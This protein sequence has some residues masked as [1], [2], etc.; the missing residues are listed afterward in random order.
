MAA[1]RALQ[2]GDVP[3]VW[4]R[5]LFDQGPLPKILDEPN[6]EHDVGAWLPLLS[7]GTDVSWAHVYALLD[8]ADG[9]FAKARSL[10]QAAI[11]YAW[12][13]HLLHGS[14]HFDELGVEPP[15]VR[16][17]QLQ[18]TP[19]V[20]AVHTRL[21]RLSAAHTKELGDAKQRRA[22]GL[23]RGSREVVARA[24]ADLRRIEHRAKRPVGADELRS[25][26]VRAFPPYEGS[27]K[28][29][30]GGRGWLPLDSDGEPLTES[31]LGRR[32]HGHV[33]S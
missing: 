7:G 33:G 12:L 4:A 3:A 22:K 32:K 14:P 11:V 5:R 8:L 28:P 27:Y 13:H 18:T 6:A 16:A 24:D 17:G 10:S 2:R 21:A 29:G 23:K 19:H 15:T 26:E 30:H 1:R 31:R 25:E 20:K 9:R